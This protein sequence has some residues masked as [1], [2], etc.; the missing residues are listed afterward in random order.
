MEIRQ[1][2]NSCEL[3]ITLDYIRSNDLLNIAAD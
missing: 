3:L 2:I 1:Q